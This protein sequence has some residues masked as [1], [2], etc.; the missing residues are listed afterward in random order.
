M[1]A[2]SAVLREYSPGRVAFWCP[3]CDDFHQIPVA[4]TREP[5]KAWGWDGDVDRPTFEPSLLVRSGHYT[6]VGGSAA[7]CEFC[8]WSDAEKAEWGGSGCVLCHTFVRGGII[9]FL[10]D[11]THALVG[12]KVPIPP[13]PEGRYE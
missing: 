12:Q 8:N 9:E 4:A 6:K 1:K 2:L 13:W 5:G 11:C 10:G 3:G 7:D